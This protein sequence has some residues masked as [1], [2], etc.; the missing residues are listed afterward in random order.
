M[1]SII[2]EQ[3][4][5]N[6]MWARRQLS[7]GPLLGSSIQRIA[8]PSSY[9]ESWEEQA[10]E[11]DSIGHLGGYTW[12]PRSYSCSFCRR[13][14]RSAQALGGHMNVHRRDRARLK[15]LSSSPSSIEDQEN[16]QQDRQNTCTPL[17]H[18]HQENTKE[19][20]LPA[21][22]S[23]SDPAQVVMLE[24]NLGRENSKQREAN[25]CR[26]LRDKSRDEEE[27][28]SSKRRCIDAIFPLV[29]KSSPGEQQN[30]RSQVLKISPGP[31]GE[32]DLEL[33]LGSHPKAK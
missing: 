24:L 5:Y 29:M 30:I 14:F 1:H 31:V 13:E 27:I 12:P 21:E 2:M 33:R 10:F 16:N 19:Q 17:G 4:K 15:Q 28:I 11:K 26:K 23:L 32:L 22:Q 9:H 8:T 3:T 20:L 6:W 7:E 25:F 18:A